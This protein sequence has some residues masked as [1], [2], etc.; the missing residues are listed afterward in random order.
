MELIQEKLFPSNR[1]RLVALSPDT[2]EE[3]RAVQLIRGHY[4]S[5]VW[6][7]TQQE[8]P[9]RTRE[10]VACDTAICREPP[11]YAFSI[12]LARGTDEIRAAAGELARVG[13]VGGAEVWGSLGA[14]A[15]RVFRGCGLDPR[16]PCSTLADTLRLA[17]LDRFVQYCYAANRESLLI[18]IDCRSGAASPTV[19]VPSG[20]RTNLSLQEL[21]SSIRTE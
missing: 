3:R 19:S 15:G 18:C 8:E 6:Q 9:R 13:M 20:D 4:T 1:F 14:D 10:L 21:R 12:D 16:N 11:G 7:A 5:V 2:K 17:N